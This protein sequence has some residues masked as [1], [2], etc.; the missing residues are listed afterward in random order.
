MI[1][2]SFIW[3]FFL[4]YQ[5]AVFPAGNIEDEADVAIVLGAA[6]DDEKPS[7]VFAER[8]QHAINLYQLGRIQKIIFTGGF[9]E[10]KQYAESLVASTYAIKQG[11]PKK[12]IFTEIESR[13]TRDNLLQAQKLLKVMSK[14][15][16]LV[17]TLVISDPLHLKRAM[18]IAKKLEWLMLNH[19]QPPQ[20]AIK[21]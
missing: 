4:G 7:P 6:V 14:D 18:L 12:D 13:T 20:V 11:I 15:N 16:G 19:P 10:N 21:V 1:Y 5:I 3:L 8:I 9:G 2:L 17:S